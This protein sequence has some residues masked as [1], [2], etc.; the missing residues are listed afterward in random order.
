MPYAD[1][2][3]P[4]LYYRLLYMWLT[5]FEMLHQPCAASCLSHARLVY[6]NGSRAHAHHINF[7][8][9]KS[10]LAC[11]LSTIK[12]K[13]NLAVRVIVRIEAST[14]IQTT[15]NATNENTSTGL[16]H[17]RLTAVGL[18]A[19]SPT[20]EYPGFGFHFKEK[21]LAPPSPKL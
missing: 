19:F 13:V 18:I 3:V 9:P 6:E 5:F 8:L 11:Y 15:M 10:E 4:A 7:E 21:S 16:M 1:F 12:C 17:T 20:V 2:G 14:A